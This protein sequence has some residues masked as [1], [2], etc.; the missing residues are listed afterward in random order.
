[1]TRQQ[2]LRACEALATEDYGL[3]AEA[4]TSPPKWHLAHTSWFFVNFVLLPNG[5]KFAWP[6]EHYPL[7]FNS[8]YKSQSEHWLQ[9]HRGNLS[10]PT[11][12]EI[13]QFRHQLDAT[14]NDWLLSF[15][16]DI[17]TEIATPIRLG[18]E[19]EQQHQELLLMDIKYILWSNPEKPA[20]FDSPGPSTDLPNN[21][22]D[23]PA[24]WASQGGLSEF[25]TTVEAQDFCFDNETPKHTVFLHPFRI[26]TSLVSNADY[27]AFI[28]EGGY[29]NPLFWLSEG[30]DWIN[31]TGVSA[32]LYWSCHD[33][34][35]YEY[36]LHGLAPLA[37]NQPVKH[38]SL[39]EAYAYARWKG[40]RLP[41]EFEWEHFATRIPVKLDAEFSELTLSNTGVQQPW[42]N[43]HGGLWE[44]TSSPY[45]P[46]PG[47]HASFD[48]FG[49]YNGKFMINQSV[50]RGGCLATPAS[51]YR[52]SYRN[53]YQANQQWMFSGIRL[54][55]DIQ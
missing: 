37:A 21:T 13:M 3:Q 36:H 18:L 4:F 39:H 51:H 22:N 28:D 42:S 29:Q 20:Y 54:A 5:I 33:G 55:E 16:G 14:M 9:G 43:V 41:S 26:A 6:N 52:V 24:W 12:K 50:L 47:Y 25:G 2:S 48:A 19:H 27:R 23:E 31:Q 8:Y 38:I 10:R 17:P 35:W 15:N 1:L 44:W 32:P 49:E 40:L 53:F 30:W 11:V 45:L 46:Y 7:L 34:D